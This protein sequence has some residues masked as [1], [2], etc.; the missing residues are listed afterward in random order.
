MDLPSIAP[1]STDRVPSAGAVTIEPGLYFP[2]RGG[3]RIEDTYLLDDGKME[4]LTGWVSK[5][6][7]GGTPP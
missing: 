6:L 1:N 7:T 4:E 5:D 3:V 2:R